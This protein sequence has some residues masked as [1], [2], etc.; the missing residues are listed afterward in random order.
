MPKTS[1]SFSIDEDLDELLSNRDD[2]NPSGA[3]NTFLHELVASG[4]G[5][6]AALAVRREQIERQLDEARGEVRRLENELERVEASLEDKR[7]NRREV[8]EAFENLHIN[9][10]LAPANPA[11]QRHAERLGM[12]PEVFLAKYQEWSE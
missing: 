5:T 10:Q 1:R 6:E 3:V 11:V 12:S 4:Q 7:E 8:F 9:G 2:I